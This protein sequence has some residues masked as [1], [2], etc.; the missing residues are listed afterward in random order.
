MLVPSGPE[1][2][3]LEI[4][5]VARVCEIRIEPQAVR[6]IRL[7]RDRRQAA[8]AVGEV[9]AGEVIRADLSL[10]AFGQV[11]VIDAHAEA[12]AREEEGRQRQVV[13]GRE[14]VVVRDADLEAALVGVAERREQEAGLARIADRERDHRG[15]EDRHA[16]EV[17]PHI[18]A[19]ALLRLLVDLD[20]GRAHFP[21]GVAGRAGREADL[22]KLELACVVHFERLGRAARRALRQLEF[23]AGE[24]ARANRVPAAGAA[25]Q[26]QVRRAVFDIAFDLEAS[27]RRIV[28][29]GVGG[30]LAF[31][32]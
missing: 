30:Y 7:V 8:V 2:E 29:G 24:L 32:L 20:A 16:L 18:A 3:V 22:R 19:L 14:V 28:S 23:R 17:N 26:S 12:A 5:A 21:V 1:A 13:I 4:T 10:A 25:L 9:V 11:A 6:E 31:A 27:L 15:V